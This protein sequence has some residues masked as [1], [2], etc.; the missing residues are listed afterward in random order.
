VNRGFVAAFLFGLAALLS[1]CGSGV[2]LRL[3]I[4]IN[5]PPS[6]LLAP[7]VVLSGVAAL[8]A[9]SVR[10]GGTI[11]QPVVTCQP[12]TFSMFWTNDANGTRG[13]VI[14]LWNCPADQ[15]TWSSG[16]IPLAFGENRITVTMVDAV[17][18]VASAVTITRR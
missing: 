14:A 3:S 16:T 9:G 10:T 18:S 5:A 13:E 1:A 11:F 17:G 7:G 6:A 15:L 12:G 4:S 2:D 8:P